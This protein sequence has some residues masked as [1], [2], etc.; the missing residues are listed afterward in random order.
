MGM[1]VESLRRLEDSVTR[2]SENVNHQLSRL[3]S[4]YVPRREVER[5]LDEL[6]V[7]LGAEEAER[8]RKIDGLRAEID[9]HQEQATTTRRWLIGTTLAAM[10]ATAG[11]VF[12]ILSHFQ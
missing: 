6:T 9:R 1:V 2:L 10:S 3:P 8:V 7:D 5:R 11:V 4:E 12:G